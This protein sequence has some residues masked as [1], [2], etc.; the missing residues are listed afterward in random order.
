M[1][2]RSLFATLGVALLGTAPVP[3]R[4]GSGSHA[5]RSDRARAFAP[6][7]TRWWVLP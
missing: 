1:S 2:I 4:R 5:M 6:P 7:S 3:A